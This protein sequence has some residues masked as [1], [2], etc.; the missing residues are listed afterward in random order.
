MFCPVTYYGVPNLRQD[1]SIIMSTECTTRCFRCDKK[2][3]VERDEDGHMVAM[4][5]NGLF[6]QADGNYGSTIFDPPRTKRLREFLEI[7]VC[8]DCIKSNQK[9]VDHAKERWQC[10][11]YRTSLFEAQ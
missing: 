3:Q 8:D 1:V 10:P 11:I 6:F 7:V 2:M 4:L 5:G 9:Q